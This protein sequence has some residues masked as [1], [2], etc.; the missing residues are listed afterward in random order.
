MLQ[1]MLTQ[2]K[3]FTIMI[4]LLLLLCSWM[5]ELVVGEL[6]FIVGCLTAKLKNSSI[7]FSA[8]V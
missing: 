8:H 7:S 6:Y 1:Y 4:I 2:Q 3:M 5:S